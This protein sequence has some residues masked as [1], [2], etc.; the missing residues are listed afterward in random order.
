[1]GVPL[2]R[3]E[4]LS[5]DELK[6]PEMREQLAHVDFDQP[7]IARMYDYWL[8]GST[9]FAIDRAV[10][11]Q[12]RKDGTHEQEYCWANRGFLGRAVRVLTRD[13]GLDQFLDL[14]SGVPTVG[15]VHEI[16]HQENPHARIAYVEWETIA[17]HHARRLLGDDE[18]RVT[19]TQADVADPESVLSAPGVAGLLDFTR[20][21]VVLACG[22][23]ELL[24]QPDLTPLVLRYRQTCA[25]GSALVLS[26]NAQLTRTDEEVAYLRQ[27]MA[28]SDTPFLA[29]RTRAEVTALLPGYE[30]LEPGVVPTAAWRPEQPVDEA[31]A[32][33][34][35]AYAAV[36]LLP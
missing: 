5:E 3:P 26:H 16:A 1:M 15:N 11:E 10:V 24:P 34:S 32:A 7:N 35:N 14:G 29:M 2:Q 28:G 33:R 6:D 25:S 18:R 31:E 8:G 17:V 9:N 20:P 21:V 30:L 4:H 13:Y 19:V 12:A 23:V 22:V 36:G 27:A